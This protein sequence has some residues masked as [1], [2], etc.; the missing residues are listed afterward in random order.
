MI[1]QQ[2]RQRSARAIELIAEHLGPPNPNERLTWQRAIEK[3][4]AEQRTGFAA[5]ARR[6]HSKHKLSREELNSLYDEF[7]YQLD[8]RLNDG[9]IDA[10]LLRYIDEHR[11]D[12][13]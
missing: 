1:Q 5:E 4:W 9:F 6:R 12:D 8:K 7:W 3:Y 13:T 10:E 11:T 2:R